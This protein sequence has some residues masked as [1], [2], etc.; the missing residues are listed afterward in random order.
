LF[1]YHIILISETW[2]SSTLSDAELSLDNRY[3]VHRCDR[4]GKRGGGV[5]ILSD[6]NLSV[7]PVL[8]NGGDAELV[9]ID[10]HLSP[11]KI[12]RLCCAYLPNT[13]PSI[14]LRHASLT[15][16]C[17]AIDH[18]SDTSHS[19]FISGDFNFPDIDWKN[20]N[21]PV[22][23]NIDSPTMEEVFVESTLGSGLHQLQLEITRPVSGT[24]LDLLFTND[25]DR[26]HN[27]KTCCPPVKSD[28]SAVAFDI[29]LGR[30][31]S[32]GLTESST[33]A[34]NFKKGNYTAINANLCLTNWNIF[35]D[36][37]MGVDE[38]YTKL[39]EYLDHLNNLFIPMKS[40][41][42]NKGSIDKSIQNL[43]HILSMDETNVSIR[44]KLNRAIGRSRA[45]EEKEFI[46]ST[47]LSSIK[48][49]NYIRKRLDIKD[50]LSVLMDREGNAVTDNHE[51][52]ELLRVHFASTYPSPAEVEIRDRVRIPECTTMTQ[53]TKVLDDISFDEVDIYNRLSRLEPK[54]ST[55]PEG[56]PAFYYKSCAISLALP[57]KIIMEAS[58]N[59]SAVPEAFKRAIIAPV[60]KGGPDKTSVDRKRPVSLTVVPCKIM[61]DIIC[62]KIYENA[63]N[64][65]IFIDEQYAYR[66]GRSAILQLLET[67]NDWINSINR[68][69][70]VDV[71]YFDF[72]SAFETVTHSKLLSMMPAFGIGERII[73]WFQA[74][75]EGRSF[76]V[77]VGDSHSSWEPVTSGCPQ[78]TV[79]GP[80]AYIIYTNFLKTVLMPETKLKVFADDSKVYAT[81]D[82]DIQSQNLQKS[83]DNF[84]DATEIIDLLLT[85]GK[86]GVLHLGDNN[87]R[88]PYFVKGV[89]LK[90]IEQVKDLGV[91]ISQDLRFNSHIDQIVKKSSIKAS[92]LMRSLSI[93]NPEP[94]I[95]LFNSFIIP[96][97]LYGSEVWFPQFQKD[98]L[99][100]QRV[101]N[102]FYSMVEYRC[103]M[104]HRHLERPNVR[105]MMV[106]RDRNMLSTIK[107]IDRLDKIFNVS[108]ARTQG[109]LKIYPQSLARSWRKGA[110]IS[111]FFAW[112][113]SSLVEYKI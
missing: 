39:L 34:R 23:R 112:R 62:G 47:N 21:W 29:S 72:K 15:S 10:V 13:E 98:H 60:H 76:T 78:G 96:C 107:Q 56:L 20:Y 8:S 31:F 12:V 77:K 1:N 87:P 84:V 16:L 81:V 108:A 30:Q 2:A 61:E 104:V 111:S 71:I 70:N 48:F 109:N 102:K 11:L 59:E 36:N 45:I 110:Q 57:L 49:F 5:C 32:A 99:R 4:R 75:L 113:V 7:S 85:A 35:F 83:I 42:S 37:C 3:N 52:A 101:V 6:R 66:P 103:D 54:L 18:I 94:Y 73:R 41:T 53:T 24:N 55:T 67:T 88:R 90:V 89:Q 46:S 33:A 28:H 92:L 86:C 82:N 91:I 25:P 68:G 58:L 9:A 65:S 17:D 74:F 106:S 69:E 51:K 79:A 63:N 44:N 43:I 64:Q 50:D 40:R 97:L 80:Q 95:R 22:S 38:M 27:L 26:I 105:D 14:L 19:V 93:K 100:I